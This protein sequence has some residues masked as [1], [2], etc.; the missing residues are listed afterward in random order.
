MAY[1]ETEELK[2]EF[3]SIDFGTGTQVTDDTVER[4]LDEASAEIDS[5][6]GVRYETPVPD[7]TSAATILKTICLWLVKDRVSSILQIKTVEPKIDQD[8]SNR[9]L[10]EQALAWLDK[11]A[12]GK[13]KFDGATI[14]TTGGSVAAVDSY[15]RNREVCYEFQAG[16]DQW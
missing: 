1:A 12:E 4:F 13:V 8:V 9:S 16:K 6:I 10:R 15:L 7:S 5:I 3:K 2:A 14:L 11:I